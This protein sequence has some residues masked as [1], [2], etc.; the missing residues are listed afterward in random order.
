MKAVMIDTVDRMLS[1]WWRA[2]GHVER[3]GG[4]RCILGFDEE[5]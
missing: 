2:T 5:T 3:V 4:G 1:G